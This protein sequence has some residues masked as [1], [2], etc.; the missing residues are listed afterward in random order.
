[1]TSPSG[2]P[3]RPTWYVGRAGVSAALTRGRWLTVLVAGAGAGKTTAIGGWAADPQRPRGSAC[4]PTTPSLPVFLADFVDAINQARRD[5]GVG[6]RAATTCW[7]RSGPAATTNTTEP[8]RSPACWPICSTAS[9]A[10]EQ[11]DRGARR[12]RAAPG[13][14]RRGPV[15]RGADPARSGRHPP[16][17]RHAR[18]AAVR[19]RPAPRHRPPD[20][21]STPTISPS[22]PTRPTSC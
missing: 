11:T 12:L 21:D 1:M 13:D 22:T 20:R 5:A 8:T 15:R 14:L 16:R 10:A 18:A 19:G 6:R 9:G 3:A 7:R 17:D 2:L 4:E